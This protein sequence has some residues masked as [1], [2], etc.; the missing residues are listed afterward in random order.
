M[1]GPKALSAF[2]GQTL[3]PRARDC[4]E[5]ISGTQG[6]LTVAT[7]AIPA[8]GKQRMYIKYVCDG[9]NAAQR[10]GVRSVSDRFGRTSHVLSGR[11]A[12][13]YRAIQGLDNSVA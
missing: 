9:F 12:S 10:G 8:G 11:N 7:V 1:I 3:S 4:M 13:V 5:N 2:V 6:F